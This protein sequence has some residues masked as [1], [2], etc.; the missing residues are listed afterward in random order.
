MRSDSES[1]VKILIQGSDVQSEEDGNQYEG[2]DHI[3][4]EETEFHLH[5]A[6]GSS[7]DS[8]HAWYGDKGNT[9][10]WGSCHGYCDKPPWG[11]SATIEE[12]GI[13]T[14]PRGKP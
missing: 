12:A 10:H 7:S 4:Y 2:N 9:R 8:D 3:A 5:V 11:F 13:R 14:L 1:V 6:H